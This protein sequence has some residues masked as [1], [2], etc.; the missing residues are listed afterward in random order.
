MLKLV[1]MVLGL[2]SRNAKRVVIPTVTRY[3]SCISGGEGFG[4]HVTFCSQRNDHFIQNFVWYLVI[5]IHFILASVARTYCHEPTMA[6]KV[7]KGRASMC[8]V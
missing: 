8:I 4:V 2:F 5:L 7:L 1:I 6:T 3:C